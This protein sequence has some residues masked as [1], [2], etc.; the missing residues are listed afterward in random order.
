MKRLRANMDR[1]YGQMNERW[2]K[3][4]I[5]RQHRYTLYLFVGYLLLTAGMIFKVWFDMAKSG[6]SIVIRHIENP[7]LKKKESPALLQDTVSI[8]IKNKVYERK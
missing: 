6:N 5:R 3:L 8:I 2:K 7:V 4:P 1:F